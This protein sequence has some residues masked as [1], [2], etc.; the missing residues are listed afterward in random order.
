MRSLIIYLFAVAVVLGL[1]APARDLSLSDVRSAGEWPA[2]APRPAGAE[3]LVPRRTM[4]AAPSVIAKAAATSHRSSQVDPM[5]AIDASLPSLGVPA[6]TFGSILE[7]SNAPKAALFAADEPES[8]Y[9][10]PAPPR[11]EEGTNLG[12]VHLDL[13]VLYS[14]DYVYRGLLHGALGEDVVGSRGQ[15]NVQ[16]NGKLSFDFGKLP[17]PWVSMFVNLDNSDSVSR[18]EEIQPSF[19][20]DWELKPLMLSVGNNTYIYPEREKTFNTSEVFVRVE[21]DDSRLWH[22]AGPVLSP[23]IYGAYDYDLYHGWYFELGMHH[24]FPISETGLTI[25]PNADVAY[26]LTNPE[27]QERLD[28]TD[29]GF[30]HFDV[31]TNFTYS[32]NHL[33]NLSNRFGQFSL[34]AYVNYT[35]GIS[36]KL[37]GD[38]VLWG[39]GGIAFHY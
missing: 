14:S 36:N 10:P 28:S 32:L 34:E 12:G 23:Y 4:S 26:V 35:N 20:F 8:V 29:S 3:G 17:H 19:G 27:F 25:S 21:L 18:F 38:S 31:G 30:Q 9:A 11:P 6:L 2:I 7:K 15:L 24:D 37:R 39:G 33:L 1:A 5:A 16:F 13:S 22:T